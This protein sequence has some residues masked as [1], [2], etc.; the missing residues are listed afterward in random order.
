MDIPECVNFRNVPGL[1]PAF[2]TTLHF[3]SFAPGQVN[4][5]FRKTHSIGG[6]GQNVAISIQQLG[7]ADKV[8]VLQFVGGSTGKY[9][10]DALE[11]KNIQQFSVPVQKPTRTCTTVLDFSTNTTTELV[12]PSNAI[13]ASEKAQFFTLAQSVLSSPTIRGIA[14]CGTL[15]AGTDAACYDFVVRMK[16]ASGWT[17]LLDAYKGVE[18]TLETGLVDILKING[19]EARAVVGD[20]T[21]PIP[22]VGRAIAARYPIRYI[23]LTNGPEAAYLVDGATRTVYT[24]SVPT[25]AEMVR[26]TDSCD[27]LQYD[28]PAAAADCASAL[29]MNPA[30]A[31]LAKLAESSACLPSP[32]M[33][34]TLS[35]QNS[36]HIGPDG[37]QQLVLN[38]LGAGD[39]CSGVTLASY[40]ESGDMVAAFRRGLAAASASCL[41]TESTSHFDRDVM[42]AIYD[43]I[44]VTSSSRDD[45]TV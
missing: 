37:E 9:I 3:R 20:T 14:I 33:A 41:V 32:I 29:R 42:V 35:R 23:A 5:A 16:P 6:K 17:I 45:A 34:P 28:P 31:Q 8:S 26:L 10:C 21:S 43:Q 24:Y 15:P 13:D 38:P 25:L 19:D 2:Q 40:L 27:Q 1:N 30:V 11:Q 4:R 18:S 12:E 39:T 44:T 36:F 7:H 22:V